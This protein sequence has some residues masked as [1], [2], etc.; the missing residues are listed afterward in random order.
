MRYLNVLFVIYPLLLISSC[1]QKNNDPV[2]FQVL[3]HTKTG[4]DFSNTLTPTKKFNVFKYMYFYNGAGVGAGDFNNDG[5]I[6]LFFTSSQGENKIYLNEGKLKFKDVTAEAKI[7]EDGGWSNGV[8]V[9]DI[10]C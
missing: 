2:L 8:S 9:V 4:L 1:K 6:D 10:G 3:D 7:P 5:L